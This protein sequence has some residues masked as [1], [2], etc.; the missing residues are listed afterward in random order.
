MK[1]ADF[2]LCRKTDQNQQKGGNRYEIY[3]R[4]KSKTDIDSF[5]FDVRSFF[6]T[7][8]AVTDTPP[9]NTD[10][11]VQTDDPIKTDDPAQTEVPAE[12]GRQY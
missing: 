9:E 7:V 12:T 1:L 4:Q 10:D 11:P 3:K 2:T 5:A 6:S 8:F